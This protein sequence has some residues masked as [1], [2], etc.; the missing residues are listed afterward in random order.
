MS[1]T[2]N[3]AMFWNDGGTF[4]KITDH[5]RQPLTVT[6]ERIEK[7]ARMVN[8]TLRRYT[9]AKKRSWQTSWEN[10]PSTNNNGGLTTADGGWAGEDIEN[11][12]DTTDGAFDMQLRDGDGTI[13]TVTV[14]ISDFSKDIAKRGVVDLWNISITLDE[15]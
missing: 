10:V 3:A 13:E 1:W 12:H 14:M 4:Q 8:G 7:K 15:V 2:S 5:N 6:I 11:F 9:V